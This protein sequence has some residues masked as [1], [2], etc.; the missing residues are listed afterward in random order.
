MPLH[1]SHSGTG[2]HAAPLAEAG[3]SVRAPDPLNQPL[4]AL[5]SIPCRPCRPSAPAAPWSDWSTISTTQ[6]LLTL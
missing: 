6:S 5:L 1:S 3:T 4:P 2:R